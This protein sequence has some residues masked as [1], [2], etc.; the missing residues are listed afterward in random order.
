MGE[1]GCFSFFG[2]VTEG[3]KTQPQDNSSRQSKSKI[4]KNGYDNA[5]C[6]A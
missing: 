2:R 4:L 5:I 1:G 6:K 3:S